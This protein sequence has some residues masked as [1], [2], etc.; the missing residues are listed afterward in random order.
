MENYV[1]GK[2][3]EQDDFIYN[4]IFTQIPP[5][6]LPNE[7][8]NENE[9]YKILRDKNCW[10][11]MRGGSKLKNF[12]TPCINSLNSSDIVIIS[13][14]GPAVTKVVSCAEVVKRRY[15]PK[16]SALFQLTKIAYRMVEEHWEPK[17]ED[18]EP[19]KVTREIPQI[20]ILLKKSSLDTCD[21]EL[22]LCNENIDVFLDIHKSKV[23]TK[24]HKSKSKSGKRTG[25]TTLG[26]LDAAKDLGLVDKGNVHGGAHKK[27]V[28]NSSTKRQK[29][30]A[31][32]SNSSGNS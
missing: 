11:Q 5:Q 15:R 31:H 2:N 12:I 27:P 21:K 23:P 17:T 14:N 24:K 16:G 1:K 3:L 7:T 28:H 25:T 18:L 10:M 13:G 32:D 19:I 4:E 9:V 29:N 6:I 26:K 30:F 20:D 8:M 22:I